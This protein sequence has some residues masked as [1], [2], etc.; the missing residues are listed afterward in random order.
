MDP[1]DEPFSPGR[2][3]AVLAVIAL[4]L[5]ALVGRVYHLQRT[6]AAVIARAD[7]QQHQTEILPARRGG[8]FDRNGLMMAG[9]RQS[10]T[11]FA[12]PKFLFEQSAA[13]VIVS[14][15]RRTRG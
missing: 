13:A 4:L 14:R 3:T 5:L 9:T 10:R 6:A 12:D 1:A 15:P 8:I 2:A 7:R 11:L